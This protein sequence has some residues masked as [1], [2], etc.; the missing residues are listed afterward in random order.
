M[1]GRRRGPEKMPMAA[2]Q[3]LAVH[4]YCL[5]RCALPSTFFRPAW[6]GAP[7]LESWAEAWFAGV[8]IAQGAFGCPMTGGLWSNP[9][10]RPILVGCQAGKFTAC[11]EDRIR[12]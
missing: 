10:V 3:L 5:R 12:F 1:A 6:P 2:L 7:K 9:A 4:A 8:R 11:H